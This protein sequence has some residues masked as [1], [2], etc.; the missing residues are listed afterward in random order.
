MA[1]VRGG[2]GQLGLIAPK[3]RGYCSEKF[4]GKAVGGRLVVVDYSA[5]CCD[6]AGQIFLGRPS[7]GATIRQSRPSLPLYKRTSG[8]GMAYLE[9]SVE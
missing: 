1:Y 4:R 6:H 2:D 3:V 8:R 7:L 9:W 5:E